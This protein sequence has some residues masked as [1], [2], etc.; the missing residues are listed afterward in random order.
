M[1]RQWVMT[2]RG[3]DACPGKYGGL[4]AQLG[5][6]AL[7]GSAIAGLVTRYF[8]TGWH[9]PDHDKYLIPWFRF[10]A[11]HGWGALSFD[12]TN[13]TP[14]YSYLLIIA[15]YFQ[16]FA[17][18]MVL[19]KAISAVFEFAN[20]LLGMAIVLSC[21]GSR[22]RA[23]L[24]FAFLWLAPSV[25]YNG[26]AW[27]QA[28]SI[29]TLFI[30]LSIGVFMHGRNGA[31]PFGAAFA[32]K[33]QAAFLGPF[34]LG[35]LM[36][37]RRF[38]WLWLL[39]VPVVYLVFAM[40]ALLSGLPLRD[41]T[42]V[43]LHQAGT[44][45]RL[46][47]NAASLWALLPDVPY[48]IGVAVGLALAVG[49]TLALA[50]VIA[51][52]PRRDPEFIL[53]AG[54]ASLLLLPFLLPKMHERY[55]YAYEVTSIVLAC[56]NPRYAVFAIIAQVDCIL[57][58]LAFDVGIVLG[59][60]AAAVEN[61]VMVFYVY[62]ELMRPNLTAASGKTPFPKGAWLCYILVLTAMAVLLAQ[63]ASEQ[64]G[65]VIAFGFVILLVLMAGSTVLLL[66]CSLQAE[67]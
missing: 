57:S 26:P 19:V 37:R 66:R 11:E 10:A 14:L 35:M 29:W 51:H 60:R 44:F 53:L 62:R 7:V 40:P 67:Q 56:I 17:S 41:V 47:M 27:A 28:D 18:P 24:A 1:E 33:A 46:S 3:T 64:A 36:R 45:N 50:R 61:L 43:Y 38:G 58:Y 16:A 25:Q 59:V 39:S 32:V 2:K 42:L 49:G 20:A 52:S 15:A 30:L 31:I 54:A 34:V 48:Y 4:F 21:S 63:T 22:T 55:F 23:Y 65:V 9:T 13:Y 6:A 5:T 12:F 8:L